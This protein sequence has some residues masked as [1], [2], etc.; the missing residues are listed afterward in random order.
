M[1]PRNTKLSPSSSKI[2]LQSAIGLVW[3]GLI[4]ILD[5]PGRSL[6]KSVEHRAYARGHEDT[7]LGGGPMV[8]RQRSFT[9]GRPLEPRRT[10]GPSMVP[11]DALLAKEPCILVHSACNPKKMAGLC[12]STD[13][14]GL[15]DQSH[16]Q[17]AFLNLPIP[18]AFVRLTKYGL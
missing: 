3:F 8:E 17:A 15:V 14:R 12:L 1:P 7:P 5:A 6:A 9:W 16:S 4:E 10:V 18:E 13:Q 11:I 2:R